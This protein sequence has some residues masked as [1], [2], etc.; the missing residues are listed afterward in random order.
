MILYVPLPGLFSFER[1]LNTNEYLKG[2]LK[3]VEGSISK[4]SISEDINMEELKYILTENNL[5][6][7]LK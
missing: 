4:W 6:Y 1:I 5:N 2:C 7:R 3:Q